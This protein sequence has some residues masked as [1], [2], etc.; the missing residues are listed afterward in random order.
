MAY[1]MSSLG[2]EKGQNKGE[3]QEEKHKQLTLTSEYDDD[4]LCR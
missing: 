3:K 2:R 1:K 4:T